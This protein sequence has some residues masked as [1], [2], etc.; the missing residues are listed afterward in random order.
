[1]EYPLISTGSEG[2]CITLREREKTGQ[3]THV[4]VGDKHALH[5]E[6]ETKQRLYRNIHFAISP[7]NKLP[8]ADYAP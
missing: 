3:A 4:P 5:G 1:M 2:S 7:V 8:H 6:T